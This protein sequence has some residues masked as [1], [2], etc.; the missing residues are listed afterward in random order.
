LRIY[1]SK[2]LAPALVLCLTVGAIAAVWLLVGRASASREA[3]LRIASMTLSLAG[4]GNAPFNADPR[5]GGSAAA[6]RKSIEADERWLSQGLAVRAQVGA[7]PILLAAGR[8][9]LAAI[10]PVVASIYRT[11]LEKGGLA[12]AGSRVP[13]L[14]GLLV[15]RSVAL[16]SVLDQIGRADATRAARAR[17]QTEL[18]ATAFTF[19]YFR[20]AQAREAVERLVGEKE[21]LL[22]VSQNEARTD[23][24][25]NL[26]N[27]R[28][29][30]DDLA[31]ALAEPRE[32]HELL[33]V[34]FDLDGFKQY[35]D[36]FG[37]AAGDALLQL[38]P[39]R[40]VATL[41]SGGRDSS[42][43]VGRRAHVC[44]QGG[45]LTGEPASHRCPAAGDR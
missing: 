36:S 43:E 41:R 45:T 40:R 35:N 28:A 27:R 17:A 31:N 32:S 14:Q 42:A 7:P 15:A 11:A 4:L 2:L 6:S 24:L 25:T 21:S 9:S 1:R 10:E 30:A 23:A 26:A 20:S 13:K 18:G 8:S 33:L 5:A 38:L 3:Q 16:T 22:G 12:G 37:H 44:Q 29:L 34:M 39:R 19:F